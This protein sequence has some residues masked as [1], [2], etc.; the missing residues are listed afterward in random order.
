[1]KK[2]KNAEKRCINCGRIIVDETNKTGLCPKCTK[3]GVAIGAAAVAVFPG[4]VAG[5]KKY[6][7]QIVQGFAKLVLKR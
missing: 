5:V 6:G 1:M 2:N 3:E 7:K 4:V